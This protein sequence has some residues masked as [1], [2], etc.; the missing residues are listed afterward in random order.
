M[1][2]RKS[3]S[4]ENPE[5]TSE[6]NAKIQKILTDARHALNAVTRVTVNGQTGQW[7][8]TKVDFVPDVKISQFSS[9]PTKTS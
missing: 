7:K 4:D 9:T 1:P 5:F 2:R 6:Q 3:D 8:I